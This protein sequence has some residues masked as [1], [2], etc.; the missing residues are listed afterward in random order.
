MKTRLKVVTNSELSC[1]R[2][3]Q[4]EHHYAYRLGF[5]PLGDNDNLR[6]GSLWHAALEVWWRG[7]GLEAALEVGTQ[8]AKDEYEA[9][10]VRVLLRGYEARWGNEADAIL[11]R[12]DVLGV[13]ETFYAPIVNPETGRSSQLYVL[14]GKL[15]V[16]LRERFIEHKTSS[17]DVGLGSIY[18]R[19]LLLNTQ[20]STYY[21]GARALGTDVEG[22]IY[23]VV[24]KPALRPSGTVPVLDGQGEKMVLDADGNR[25]MTKGGK[26]WR[27]TADAELG[28]RLV[29]RDET[30]EEYEARLTE[31]IA[32]NPDKYYQRGE[33]VRLEAEEREAQ[34]DVWQLVH[35]MRE[36][37]LADSHPRNADA[38]QRYGSLCGYFDVCSGTAVL[39]DAARFERVTNVHPELGEQAEAAE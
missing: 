16:R 12:G 38:C 23:D 3:C 15:D 29:V 5:R 26:R 1:F 17:E 13:E 8:G 9:A 34:L 20:V 11:G 24:R 31:E 25:V 39:E 2:R 19:R 21:A 18:W 28:Y 14:G 4:R 22:C 27:Q 10:K 32:S 33:V 30:V 35:A 6:F 36:A 37:E 7:E